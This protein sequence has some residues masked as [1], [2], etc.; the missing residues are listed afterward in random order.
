MGVN[1]WEPE[2]FRVHGAHPIM[3]VNMWASHDLSRE[4]FHRD[5]E[6]PGTRLLSRAGEARQEVD[7]RHEAKQPHAMI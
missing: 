5:F 7:G 3:R 1:H 4:C 6:T 2:R